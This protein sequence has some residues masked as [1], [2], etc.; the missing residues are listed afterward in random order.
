MQLPK[1]VTALRDIIDRA[2]GASTDDPMTS[3]YLP[4][5]L[6]DEVLDAG[7]PENQAKRLVGQV[8]D[9][10]YSITQLFQRHNYFKRGKIR[11]KGETKYNKAGM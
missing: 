8:V 6:M 2:R 7:V 5:A 11:L 1:T 3:V 4:K 9:L 10:K